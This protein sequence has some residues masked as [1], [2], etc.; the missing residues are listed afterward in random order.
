M[1][2]MES[3]ERDSETPWDTP[4]E[5]RLLGAGEV[6]RPPDPAARPRAAGTAH[7][8]R[9]EL[10][11]GASD[12]EG[13]EVLLLEGREKVGILGGRMA[14]KSYLFHAMVER[15]SAGVNSG[16]L[17][18]FLEED[19]TRLFSALDQGAPARLETP[20]RFLD[21]YRRWQRLDTTLAINQKWYLLT[22]SF[23]VG[24]LGHARASLDVE[25]FDG[26]GEQFFEALRD[27][28]TRPI[29]HRAYLDARVMV[30]CL[31]IWAAFPAADLDAADWKERDSLL[32]GFEQVVE[33]YRDLR[34]ANHPSHPVKSLLAL[35]MA[36]DR[37]SA[38]AS[39][40]DRWITPYMD[41][42]QRYLPRL[43]TA[44]GVARYLANAR[45]VSEAVRREFESVQDNRV[46][47]I[48]AALDFDA[49]R[50]WLIPVSA[51]EG[52]ALAVHEDRGSTLDERR[53]LASPVPAHVELPLLVALCE[54]D[55]ALM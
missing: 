2:A 38:L 46:A 50:P 52:A 12:R 19:A 10:E 54:R 24:W 36:D 20:A 8:G 6:V 35:T 11:L 7:A 37:R 16:A 42:P 14:G 13:E 43:R 49:G 9:D 26:S 29:W 53:H 47:R 33:N 51:V 41:A 40:R 27:E 44:S 31:P 21:N 22:L 55:N 23:R 4:G 15:T 5:E 1:R 28:R 3:N 18:Y 30:F 17:G 48:P 45:R 34:R 39:V 25:F 32:L